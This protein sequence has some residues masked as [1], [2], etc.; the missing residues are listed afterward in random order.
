M[1]TVFA[2]EFDGNVNYMCLRG[3]KREMHYLYKPSGYISGMACGNL[4]P[5]AVQRRET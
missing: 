3:K 4:G 5:D 1:G 2:A